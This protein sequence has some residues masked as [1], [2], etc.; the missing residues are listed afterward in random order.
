[1]RVIFY[2]IESDFELSLSRVSSL[3]LTLDSFVVDFLEGHSPLSE[4]YPFRFY[5]LIC[6]SEE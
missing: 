1:M 2:D 5:D 6:V 4:S 3:S